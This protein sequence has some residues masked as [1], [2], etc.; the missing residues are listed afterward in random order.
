MGDRLPNDDTTLPEASPICAKF[1]KLISAD[2]PKE[3][4]RVRDFESTHVFVLTNT[5]HLC[6]QLTTS[7]VMEWKQGSYNKNRIQTVTIH[8]SVPQKTR[9]ND[10]DT[11]AADEESVKISDC[12]DKYVPMS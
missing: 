2:G 5:L 1:F 3:H 12:I 8:E 9:G 6:D 10:A 11:G 7:L 4:K